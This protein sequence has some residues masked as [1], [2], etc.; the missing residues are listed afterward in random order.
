M[1]IKE[2]KIEHDCEGSSRVLRGG[3]WRDAASNVRAAWRFSY[4]PGFRYFIFG[5]RLFLKGSA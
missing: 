1:N 5:F 3:S 2:L 4:V